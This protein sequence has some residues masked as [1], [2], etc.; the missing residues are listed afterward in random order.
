MRNPIIWL[1]FVL[2]V[3]HNADLRRDGRGRRKRIRGNNGNRNREKVTRA[4]LVKK[5]PREDLVNYLFANV[6][7][8]YSGLFECKGHH[9]DSFQEDR[10]CACDELCHQ[11]NDCCYDIDYVLGS[12]PAPPQYVS[13]LSETSRKYRKFGCLPVINKQQQQNV[14]VPTFEHEVE[15]VLGIHQCL[16]GTSCIDAN[17]T[18]RL[19]KG[20]DGVLYANEY[21]AVCNGVDEHSY[22][23]IAL[24]G[25]FDDMHVDQLAS[26]RTDF[27]FRAFANKSCHVT[28]PD[29]T[30]TVCPFGGVTTSFPAKELCPTDRHYERCMAF[31]A[32]VQDEDGNAYP[33]PACLQCVQ[34]KTARVMDCRTLKER[35][36]P[37]SLLKETTI[38]TLRAFSDIGHIIDGEGFRPDV[39]FKVCQN[40]YLDIDT[41]SC[42]VYPTTMPVVIEPTL[43]AVIGRYLK[44][45][46]VVIAPTFI[47]LSLVGLVW[48]LITFC[49]FKELKHTAGKVLFLLSTVLFAYFII[50]L[51]FVLQSFNW[52]ERRNKVAL[53]RWCLTCKYLF[54]VVL[55][56]HLRCF[57]HYNAKP[58]HVQRFHLVVQSTLVFTTSTIFIIVG[59]SQTLFTLESAAGRLVFY[60]LP[61]VAS[62][63]VALLLL[64]SALKQAKLLKESMKHFKEICEYL[65]YTY[66]RM[67][68]FLVLVF[69]S[70]C[71]YAVY[72]EPNSNGGDSYILLNSI[73]EFIFLITN[74]LHGV[75]VVVLLVVNKRVLGMYRQACARIFRSVQSCFGIE[76]EVMPIP[77]DI[78]KFRQ[79][80][81][82]EEQRM[83]TLQAGGHA[84]D[85][86]SS[87]EDS[88]DVETERTFISF[89]KGGSIAL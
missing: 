12:Q 19:V 37:A 2:L 35:H 49:Y 4:P 32:G 87:D 26:N 13:Q 59:Q 51:K 84:D 25:C 78:E 70:D 33:N 56:Y 41:M 63:V 55:A 79:R 8:N 67:L 83:N 68:K 7:G 74:S 58:N 9:V 47:L 29:P 86:V 22:P 5:D 18:V 81:E 57:Q 53:L 45:I 43:S 69:I 30:K 85:D 71:F 20:S 52:M 76:P 75:F 28:L 1:T 61:V 48:T 72:I 62:S 64:I 15:H 11:R 46:Q 77:F 65:E 6:K 38:V 80:R 34:S 31:F 60:L 89:L 54:I 21:C 39:G 82:E 36:S 23:K 42:F 88:F 44:K 3:V 40:G 10:C 50:Q 24:S 17:N 66:N 73:C 16:N 14:S 27:D